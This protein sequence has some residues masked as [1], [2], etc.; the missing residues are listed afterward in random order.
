MPIKYVKGKKI[1]LPYPK[2]RKRPT[3][4]KLKKKG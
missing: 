3:K 4:K 1:H 2:K